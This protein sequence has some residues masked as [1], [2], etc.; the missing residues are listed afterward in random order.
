MIYSETFLSLPPEEYW[1]G[2]LLTCHH[3]LVSVAIFLQLKS[4]DRHLDINPKSVEINEKTRADFCGLLTR[5]MESTVRCSI[6]CVPPQH[7]P[8][9]KAGVWGVPTPSASR[10]PQIV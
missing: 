10:L 2:S 5:S 9:T 3:Y 8:R 1:F 6:N 7:F 4:I